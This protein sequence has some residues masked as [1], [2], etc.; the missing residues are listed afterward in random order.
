[1]VTSNSPQVVVSCPS[2]YSVIILLEMPPEPY[3][4][5]ATKADKTKRSRY[6]TSVIFFNLAFVLIAKAATIT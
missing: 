2:D 3:M 1:M 6:F 5:S 4:F